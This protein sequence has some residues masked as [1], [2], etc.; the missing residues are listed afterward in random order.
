MDGK[1]MTITEQW[2]DADRQCK[3]LSA[4]VN[5]GK[6]AQSENLARWEAHRNSLE[7][8]GVYAILKGEE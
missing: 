2:L 7:D 6:V 3:L 5:I 4:R 1:Q 8:D